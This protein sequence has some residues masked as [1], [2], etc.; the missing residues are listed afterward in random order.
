[1]TTTAPDQKTFILGLGAQKAGTT[2]LYDYLASSGRMA[3]QRIK[4]YHIWD[5]LHIPGLEHLR[6]RP[7]KSE[8][9][10]AN[11]VRFFMQQSPENYF[12]Y[13]AYMM[14]QQ[15]KAMA[16][17]ITPMY[18]GLDRRVLG[19]IRTG[20]AERGI[21][22]KAVFL[23]RDPV[24]RCWSAARME[25]RNAFGHTG[26]DEDAVVQHAL[27]RLSELRTRYDVT[28]AEIEAAFPA[29]DI[30]LGIYE[31]MFEP[32][33]IGGLSAFLG[34]PVQQAHSERRLNVS[35]VA[36][37]IS[38]AACARVAG[39]FRSVYAF[40]ARRFPQ[41]TGLWSGFRYL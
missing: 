13:F 1:M 6:V 40:A 19:T 24:E 35:E 39:H 32:A 38:D 27:S 37:P 9:G 26:I 3:T 31:E 15:G 36:T 28:V 4:E 7:E 23:M 17:D 30:H 21:A 5:G 29:S 11:R 33:S 25:S 34:V 2:W 10:F 14:Q 12:T 41:T 22:T 8:S 18:S 16:C 20:F